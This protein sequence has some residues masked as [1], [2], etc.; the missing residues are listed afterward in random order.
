MPMYEFICQDC[1]TVFETIVKSAEAIDSVK[2]KNCQSNNI[3]KTVSAGIFRTTT[4]TPVPAAGCSSKSGF[5]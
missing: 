2:C 3:K 5:R 1:N 4:G